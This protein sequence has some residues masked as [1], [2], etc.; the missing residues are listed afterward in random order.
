MADVDFH[1]NACGRCCNSAPAMSVA[2]LL[3]HRGR[4]IGTLAVGLV[5]RVAAGGR[6]GGQVLGSDDAAELAALQDALFHPSTRMAGHVVSLVAQ[7]WDYPSLDRCPALGADGG[8]AV[9]GPDKPVMCRVVPLDPH[10]P[11]RLQG[12]A[13]PGRRAS[14]AWLGAN[15]IQT[16]TAA[17]YRPLVRL[18]R[19]A[20]DGYAA[21]LRRRR[22]DLLE[23]KRR[24]GRAVFRMLEGELAGAARLAPGGYL[25]MP[26][27]PVLAV[28]AAEGADTRADCVAYI[29]AQLALIDTAT[30]AALRRK[31][32]DDKAGTAQLRAFAHAYTR[33]R[34][35]FV[36]G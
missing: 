26:L 2:E 25:V 6:L 13:L 11:D 31:R 29:D 24:W 36:G 17:P 1:C 22:D 12:A 4:F 8:C 23:D 5:P 10:L 30:E 15:C 9:H 18:H 34:A 3:R 21:D 20:D 7:A 28:L 14:A 19:V 32:P 33:Q 27:A 16:D 35:L